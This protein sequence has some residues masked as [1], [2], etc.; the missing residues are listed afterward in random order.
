MQNEDSRGCDVCNIGI[1]RTSFAKHSKSKNQLKNEIFVRSIFAKASNKS[2][3]TKQKVK[4]S[5][6]LKKIS[7]DEN[8]VDDKQLS[9]EIFQQ[10]IPFY[11]T[12]K[13]FGAGYNI[14]LGSHHFNH[15]NSKNTI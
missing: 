15:L 2:N 9:K 3:K 6:S 8:K 14:N 7:K 10:K 5:Q 4:S 13:V 1:P 12:H 11:F